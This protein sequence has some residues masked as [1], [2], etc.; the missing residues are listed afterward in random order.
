MIRTVILL[1]VASVAVAEKSDLCP[2]VRYPFCS[3]DYWTQLENPSPFCYYEPC[4]YSFGLFDKAVE[5]C[6]SQGGI[7][8]VFHSEA[9]V[10]ALLDHYGGKN[11]LMDYYS[12][13]Q[14]YTGL[15]RVNESAPWT[16]TDGSDVDFF[17]WDENEPHIFGNDTYNFPPDVPKDVCVLMSVLDGKWST[18]PCWLEGVRYFSCF[19]AKLNGN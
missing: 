15:K 1:L 4:R 18:T 11:P 8:P 3:T 5:T 9:E 19:T 10:K 14:M 16:W 7:L 17:Y 12:S 13:P 6:A 2:Y